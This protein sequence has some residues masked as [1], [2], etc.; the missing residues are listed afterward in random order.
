[1]V[2]FTEKDSYRIGAVAKATGVSVETLRY[3]ERIGLL[4]RPGR[5]PGGARRY[6]ADAIRRVRFIKQAQSLGLRLREILDLGVG[7]D[8][9]GAG[10]DCTSVLALLTK[11][12]EEIDRRAR[13]LR[14]LRRTLSEYRLR[15]E[16]ALREGRDSRCPTLE[17]LEEEAHA[18][19]RVFELARAR[20][21]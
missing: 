14:A 16:G 17:A 8:R 20:K 6:D 3:Y 4:Q 7:A 15:C 18:K 12:I 19:D 5:N 2:V 13:E 10:A 11:H 9:P 21:R 1:M